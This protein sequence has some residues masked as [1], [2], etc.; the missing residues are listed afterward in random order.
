MYGPGSRDPPVG[1]RGGGDRKMTPRGQMSAGANQRPPLSDLPPNMKMMFEPRPPLPHKPPMTKRKMPPYTGISQY[2][3]L[4]E[5]ETPEKPIVENPKERKKRLSEQ[6]MKSNQE[7]NELLIIDWDPKRNFKATENAYSTLFIARLSYDTSEKKLRREFEQYGPIRTVKLVLDNNG[8][9]RGYAFI[10]FEREEDM[11]M[12]YKRADGKKIDGRRI[13]VDVE[14]GRTV[15]KWRPRRFGGGLGGRRPQKSKKEIAEEQLKALQENATRSAYAPPPDRGAREEEGIL[16]VH[17]GVG[18][19]IGE[20]T[21]HVRI[22]LVAVVAAGNEV[23][24]T[25]PGMTLEHEEGSPTTGLQIGRELAAGIGMGTAA[26]AE[27]VARGLQVEGKG[28]PTKG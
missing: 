11:T 17:E 5:K 4:F 28:G 13:L 14:R 8:K 9:P 6:L 25:D 23:G 26:A 18:V 15:Q 16:G 21:D 27:D 3:P 1:G 24:E 22:G 2:I 7:K 19:V 12:A 20:K 10:E